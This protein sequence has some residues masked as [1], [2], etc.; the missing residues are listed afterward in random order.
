MI[1]YQVKRHVFHRVHFYNG[2]MDCRGVW[3]FGLSVNQFIKQMLI[4]LLLKQYICSLKS[5]QNRYSQL[6]YRDYVNAK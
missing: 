2:W 4:I 6:N 3:P 5:K 1:T